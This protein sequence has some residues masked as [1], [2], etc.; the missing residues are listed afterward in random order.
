MNKKLI[1][2]AMAATCFAASGKAQEYAEPVVFE[3]RSVT[4]RQI[5]QHTWVGT[6][7]LCYN[8]SVYL[9]EGTERALLI[10]CGAIM[11]FLDQIAARLTR[12]PITLVATHLHGD[13]TGGA[14]KYFDEIHIGPANKEQ[15]EANFPQ[16]QGK[17]Q[18]LTDGQVFDLGGRQIEVQFAPGHT[19]SEV[20]FYDRAAHY[21]FCGDTFGTGYLLVFDSARREIETCT[22]TIEYMKKNGIEK[23]YPGH[24]AGHNAENISTIT[25]MQALC[26]KAVDGKITIQEVNDGDLTKMASENGISVFFTAE[27]LK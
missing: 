3:S 26:Q 13:H 10:D 4:F 14:V 12:K 1:A 23:L 5:D 20:I 2:I 11:P 17:V 19:T 15:I 27:S 7:H 24:Y 25:D 22:K 9:V 21:G 8:E 6:G 16:Y 18:K